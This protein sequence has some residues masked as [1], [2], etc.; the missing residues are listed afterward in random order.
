MDKKT[1]NTKISSVDYWKQVSKQLSHKKSEETSKNT[2]EHMNFEDIRNKIEKITEKRR[3][4]IRTELDNSLLN[5]PVLIKKEEKKFNSKRPDFFPKRGSF[6]FND[7]SFYLKFDL[8]TLFYIFYNQKG[9]VQQ[10]YAAA[11]LKSFAWRFHLRYKIWFQ[12]LEE[13]KLITTEYEKGEFLFFDFES[14][15]NFMKKNDFVFEYAYLEY[16]DQY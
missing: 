2:I 6:L 15:W 13:P 1:D 7:P 16:S 9:T 4:I 12:R 3:N 10:T 5:R 11:R 8:D 14:T